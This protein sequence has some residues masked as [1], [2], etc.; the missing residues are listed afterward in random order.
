MKKTAH[1]VFTMMLMLV[2]AAA[3]FAFSDNGNGTVTDAA[4]GL[5]W[6]KCSMGRNATDCTGAG[7]T[8]N[9]KNALAYC[10]GLSLGGRSDWRLPNVKELKSI[11]DNNKYNP[12][13]NTAF[14]PLTELAGYWTSSTQ[15]DDTTRAWAV[16]FSDGSVISGGSKTGTG[17]YVRCVAGP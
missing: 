13:I 7:T 8:D 11:V 6:Q 14:F 2:I 4:T 16:A 5:V 3:L 9:W 10:E 17:G 1:Q 15:A 12:S